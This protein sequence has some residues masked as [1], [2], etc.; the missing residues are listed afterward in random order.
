MKDMDKC[1]FCMATSEGEAS[2]RECLRT[3]WQRKEHAENQQEN[4]GGYDE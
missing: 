1:D 4:S 3:S 2:C